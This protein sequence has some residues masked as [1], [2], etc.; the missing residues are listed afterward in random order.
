MQ[1]VYEAAKA[2]KAAGIPKPLSF[3]VSHAVF[4]NWMSGEGVDVVNNGNGH[5]GLATEATFDTPEAADILGLLRKMDDEGL[6]NVFANT[7]GSST[8]SSPWSP[9]DSSMLI[10]TSTAKRRPPSP[11]SGQR[12]AHRAEAGTT[13]TPRSSTRLTWCPALACSRPPPSPGQVHPAA[14][15]SSSNTRRPP[16]TAGAARASCPAGQRQGVPQRRLPAHREVDRR[17]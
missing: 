16:T 17:A 5:D 2:L 10:E 13:S 14:P 1:E 11:G 7:E 12:P 4:E 3:K 8:T 15:A 6:V 9:R